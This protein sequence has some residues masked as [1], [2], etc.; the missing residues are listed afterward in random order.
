MGLMRSASTLG[1][2]G[3]AGPEPTI[4]QELI[5]RPSSLMSFS[6]A[7]GNPFEIVLASGVVVRVP[8]SFE[9]AALERLLAVLQ[10]RAC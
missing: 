1:G 3:S 10:A 2:A 6:D 9:A 8:T 7:R 4:F 5:V